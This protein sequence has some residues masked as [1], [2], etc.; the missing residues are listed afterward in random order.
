MRADGHGYPQYLLNDRD[1]RT[2][3]VHS[4]PD[5]QVGGHRDV[6]VAEFGETVPLPDPVGTDLD[7][8]ILK[9]CVR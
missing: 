1:S 3:T 9:T 7:A 2:L 5:R 8:E 4:H 6:R